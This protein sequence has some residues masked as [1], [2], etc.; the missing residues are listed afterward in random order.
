[1][2]APALEYTYR[3]RFG[4]QV[5]ATRQGLRLRLAT[6][7]GAEEHPYFFQGQLRRP[8]RAADLLRGL[9]AIVQARFH[10]PGIIRRR[11]ADPVV[12]SSEGALRF[13]AFSSCCSAYARAD[14][15]PPAFQGECMG[16]STTNVDF[17]PPFR[18]ALARIRAG[19]EVGQ[20]VGAE[21]VELIRA[22]ESVR[23]RKVALPL[24]WLKGFVEVQACQARMQPRLDVAGAEA[25][26][27]FRSL[28]RGTVKEGW[29]TPLGCGLRLGRTR[30]RGNRPDARA[31]GCRGPCPRSVGR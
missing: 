5:E 31:L 23:E 8:E 7:G 4:S 28:P 17:N 2:A 6:C 25:H 18:A 20:A 13:E 29:V 11:L 14:F 9:A 30:R 12:T 10:L 15:L 27:F 16:R 19:E 3:Y 22:Q 26:R 21:S 1:M 24:R